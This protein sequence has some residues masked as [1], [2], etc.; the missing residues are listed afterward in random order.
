MN[1]SVHLGLSKD[2]RKLWFNWNLGLIEAIGSTSKY[3]PS[4]LR[5]A[6]DENLIDKWNDLTKAQEKHWA[7]K[8]MTV[9]VQEELRDVV[10]ED[11]AQAE[12][13]DLLPCEDFEGGDEYGS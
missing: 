13:D 12:E 11:E 4:P 8:L 7:Q 3:L 6:H 2:A 1:V 9:L 10:A 5:T